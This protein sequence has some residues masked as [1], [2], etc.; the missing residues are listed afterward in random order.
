MRISDWR[1]DVCSSDLALAEQILAEATL[2]ALEHVR[3]RFQRTL[4]GARDRATAAAVVEQRLDGFLPHALF[5]ADDDVRRAQLHQP[6]QA[7]E[8]PSGRERVWTYV[9]CSGVDDFLT[10]KNTNT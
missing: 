4:V 10:K 2:L 6:L 1:S 9:S 7:I 5:V 8:R 3:Q